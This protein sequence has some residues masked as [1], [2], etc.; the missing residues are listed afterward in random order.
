MNLRQIPAFELYNMD[1]PDAFNETM[2]FR[3]FDVA[4]RVRKRLGGELRQTIIHV[5]ESN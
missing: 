3:T 4:D 5:K 1:K 2:T